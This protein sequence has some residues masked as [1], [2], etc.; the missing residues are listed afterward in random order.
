MV[1]TEN[2]DSTSQQ[3]IQETKR[4]L[5]QF[6]GGMGHQMNMLLDS[7]MATSE[8]IW[9]AAT[10]ANNDKMVQQI[11][12]INAKCEVLKRLVGDCLDFSETLRGNKRPELS[13]ETFDVAD[14][15]EGLR[16]VVQKLA[17]KNAN[18]I[19]V[20]CAEGLGSMHA[21]VR[22]VRQILLNLLVNACKFTRN[23][24]V[25]LRARRVV[26]DG[27]E[28]ILFEVIDTGI[29]MSQEQQRRLF[30]SSSQGEEPHFGLQIC[31]SF[32]QM[33]GGSIAVESE[34]GKG[35]V[36]TVCIPTQVA[37]IEYR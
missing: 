31:H 12:E 20:H 28:F 11:Q 35:A 15:I 8:E 33:M 23:G 18:E 2:P 34:V 1:M 9:I 37:S 26:I 17:D 21:D 10:E 4:L 7:I 25:S 13:L 36:F 27:D 30:S 5:A 14:L 24:T 22:R 6:L 29:G 32:C 3:R 16:G 19:T